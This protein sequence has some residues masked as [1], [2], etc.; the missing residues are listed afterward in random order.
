MNELWLDHRK[1]FPKGKI[2]YATIKD[3]ITSPTRY[4]SIENRILGVRAELYK[5]VPKELHR[6]IETVDEFRRVVCHNISLYFTT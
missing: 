4:Q 3:A 6:D 2:D 5:L 1:A